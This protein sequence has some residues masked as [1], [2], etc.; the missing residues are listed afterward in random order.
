MKVYELKL[1]VIIEVYKDNNEP[2]EN[3]I[4]DLNIESYNDNIN[5]HYDSKEYYNGFKVDNIKLK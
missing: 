5:I 2:I 3:I 4:N 1:T